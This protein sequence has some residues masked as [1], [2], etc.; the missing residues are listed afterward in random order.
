MSI[1]SFQSYLDHWRRWERSHRGYQPDP[2]R[3]GISPVAAKLLQE[4][5]TPA[6]VDLI[7]TQ[8]RQAQRPGKSLPGYPTDDRKKTRHTT[9][10]KG[11]SSK[12]PK[13]RHNQAITYV[14]AYFTYA[15]TTFLYG[16]MNELYQLV[17]I[18]YLWQTCHILKQ[19]KKLQRMI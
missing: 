7:L 2:D 19:Q 13:N 16:T 15:L 17:I 11:P 8:M 5:K 3:Y 1:K 18:A 14:R 9:R 12:K 10:K 4:G 6:D